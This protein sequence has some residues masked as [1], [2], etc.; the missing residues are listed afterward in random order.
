VSI[1]GL[2]LKNKNK[3]EFIF[4]RL[5]EL[6]S[7]YPKK[8]T[9]LLSDL[10]NAI[11]PGSK[12]GNCYLFR[13]EVPN[14]KQ[15]CTDF[16]MFIKQIMEIIPY[17]KIII[18]P[19]IL[20]RTKKCNQACHKCIYFYE[21]ELK[22]LQINKIHRQNYQ[23]STQILAMD[24]NQLL[25]YFFKSNKKFIFQNPVE[26]ISSILLQCKFCSSKTNLD[27]IHLCCNKALRNYAAMYA[28]II[29]DLDNILAYSGIL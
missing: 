19:T 28:R 8:I 16:K 23:H 13:S 10:G 18:I 1:P 6:K 25:N 9:I 5:R 29:E 17:V 14:A 12:Q 22:L 11:F 26:T 4:K 27:Y 15:Y 3:K 20:R 7:K 24:Y 21:S 2:D